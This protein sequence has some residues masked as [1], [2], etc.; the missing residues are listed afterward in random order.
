MSR[1]TRI[2]V[3]DSIVWMSEMRQ[4][5]A[6]TARPVPERDQVLSILL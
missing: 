5:R 6:N 1:T 4:E 3:G 2:R